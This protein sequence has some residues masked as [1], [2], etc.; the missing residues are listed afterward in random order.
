M[1]TAVVLLGDAHVDIQNT[2]ITQA[3]RAALAVACT[4]P[5]DGRVVEGC[6]LRVQSSYVEGRVW[7]T[8][9]RPQ[10]YIDQENVFVAGASIPLQDVRVAGCSSSN[11]LN[12]SLPRPSGPGET[13]VQV[14]GEGSALGSAMQS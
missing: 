13:V 12:H 4:D 6:H 2:S 9:Q 1:Q 5:E 3:S 10:T 14:R 11:I 8:D 7:L